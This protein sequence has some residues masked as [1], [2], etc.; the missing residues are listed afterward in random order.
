[1]TIAA[2]EC[3]NKQWTFWGQREQRDEA[4]KAEAKGTDCSLP[5]RPKNLLHVSSE[6]H[7][8]RRRVSPCLS[9][10]P[11]TRSMTERCPWL[12]H[13]AFSQAAHCTTWHG[14]PSATRALLA[15]RLGTPCGDQARDKPE[16]QLKM[17]VR[18]QRRHV[19]GHAFGQCQTITILSSDT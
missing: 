18:V 14:A 16:K 10:T 3:M 17:L 2:R 12:L 5:G 19:V 13:E 1:M 8:R 9:S 11:L 6:L 7:P 4:A 15:A